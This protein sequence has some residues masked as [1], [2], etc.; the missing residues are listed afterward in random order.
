MKKGQLFIVT[1]L[2]IGFVISGLMILVPPLQL[3]TRASYIETSPTIS[4]KRNVEKEMV[5]ISEMDP[6]D[7]NRLESAE[8]SLNDLAKSK[9]IELNLTWGSDQEI[10]D[11]NEIEGVGDCDVDLEKS[12]TPLNTSGRAREFSLVVR[13]PGQIRINS[14]FLVCWE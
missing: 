4:M 9:G 10:D 6:Y 8:S 1:A 5:K 13:D 11:L 2:I 7:D 3:E 12:M 14:S